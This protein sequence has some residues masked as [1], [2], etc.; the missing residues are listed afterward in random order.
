MRF[1]KTNFEFV[2]K[3]LNERKRYCSTASVRKIG[4]KKRK[5]NGFTQLFRRIVYK[6]D[7]T[8]ALT[9]EYLSIF[10]NIEANQSYTG[11]IRDVESEKEKR[12]KFKQNK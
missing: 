2:N 1:N 10:H 9:T 6:A 7:T 11:I 5:K 3:F 4:K 12:G 8:V